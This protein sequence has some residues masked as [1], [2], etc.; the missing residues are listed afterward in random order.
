MQFCVSLDRMQKSCTSHKMQI[1]VHERST[2]AAQ[3]C[4]GLLLLGAS[5]QIL[6]WLGKKEKLLGFCPSMLSFNTII[7]DSVKVSLVLTELRKLNI[8]V[9][10]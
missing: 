9:K 2:R 7:V 10:Y 5:R 8:Y 1:H 4:A 6:K 3:L